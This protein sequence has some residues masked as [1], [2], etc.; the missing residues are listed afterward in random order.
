ML[1]GKTQAKHPNQFN[2]PHRGMVCKIFL[3]CYK[4]TLT[5]MDRRKFLASSGL[6]A[7]T[8]FPLLGRSLK[9]E[10][11]IKYAA[12]ARS[13]EAVR[14]SFR[15]TD[16]HVQMAQ[17]LFA[18]HPE[19]VREAIRRHTDEFDKDPALYWEE[20]W[21][22][23]EENLQEAAMEYTGAGPG[24]IA[25][26]DSTTQGLGLLYTGL[27]LKAGDEILTTTHDHYSTEKSLEYAARRSGATIKRIDE[28]AEP[29]R[30]T[31]AEITSNIDAAISPSTRVVAV[32]WVHS[33]DGVKL[34]LREISE[35]VENANAG[36]SAD[37]RIYFCV[38]GVHGFG[39]QDDDLTDLGC[40]FFVAGTHKWLFGP[41]GT[42]LLWARRDA[43]DFLEPS[44]P[45]FQWNPFAQ[46]LHL[47]HGDMTFRDLHSPG[48]FHAFEHRW[49]LPEA[50][51][52]AGEIGRDRIH[53]RTTE[54]S[55]RLKKGI[56]EI[57]KIKLH[58]PLDPALSAGINAFEIG[59]LSA[60]EAVQAFHERNI[61]ASSSPYRVSYARLTPC[62]I[63]T[64]EEVDRCLEALASIAA[65]S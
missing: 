45:A 34:P 7:G 28:Y 10:K 63:N 54:L 4:P 47:D 39:N 42:G 2:P 43:W 29:A 48:G 49:A 27:K 17:M 22:K 5:M 16:R 9:A 3:T 40:D 35:V 53:Q 14:A 61:V 30:A 52:F 37:R 41:R 26:T 56:M 32:T 18:S 15:L 21:Q 12:P 31:T 46:W 50:F 55:T 6:A 36:R 24:E 1:S 33:C 62:V 58:T 38:D 20:E 19:P 59:S 23:A 60:A 44:I 57:P 51:K 13:W 11:V 65:R 64:E 25:F 8:V